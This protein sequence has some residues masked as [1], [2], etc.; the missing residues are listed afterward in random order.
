VRFPIPAFANEQQIGIRSRRSAGSVEHPNPNPPINPSGDS[1]AALDPVRARVLALEAGFTE[2]GLVALPYPEAERD[3]SRFSG[4]I[5][6]GRAATMRY[7][8]RVAEDGRLIRARV[9]TPFPWA[10]S[11]I[12]CF[13]SYAS[14]SEPLSTTTLEHETSLTGSVD[15]PVPSSKESDSEASLSEP[16]NS[17]L[18]SSKTQERASAWIARYAWSSRVDASGK[19]VASDYHKVLLKRLKALESRLHDQFGGFESRAYVDTGPVVERSLAVAAGLGWTG[20]N[21]C[22]IHPKLG[23]FG[24]L[25]VLLT[26]LELSKSASQQVSESAEDSGAGEFSGIRKS[27]SASQPAGGSRGLQAPE[28]AHNN[29]G[30]SG[31]DLFPVAILPHPDRCGSCTRCIQA[32]PTNALDTPYQMDANRCIAYLTIEHKGPIDES[33]MP[34]IGRQVFGCDICQDVCPWNSKSRRTGPITVDP[35]LEPRPELINPTLDWLASLD[36]QSFERLF[37]GSPVRRTGF[38]GLRRNIAIA[39]GNSGLARFTPQIATWTEAADEGLRHAARWAI[40]RLR[41]NAF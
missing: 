3:A 24:F 37:N 10:R 5:G 30:P 33:L 23:S 38:N 11:A 9:E 31:P 21:T 20:K 34:G 32:C 35:E 41:A 1:G 17:A 4:W 40:A 12:V 28:T 6:D 29:D 13:S 2:A 14:H 27:I 22:L 7:L 8:E 36:E 26:S 16:A 19:R 25:A 39:M 18:L 15:F